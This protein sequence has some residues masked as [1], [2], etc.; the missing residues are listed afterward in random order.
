MGEDKSWKFYSSIVMLV[1]KRRLPTSGAN[2][3][4]E[5]GFELPPS[6]AMQVLNGR[7]RS[8]KT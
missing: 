8:T 4:F 7:S 3:P 6:P 5:F 1:R 2:A